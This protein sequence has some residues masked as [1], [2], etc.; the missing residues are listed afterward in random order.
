MKKPPKRLVIK[1]GRYRTRGDQTAILVGKSTQDPQYPWKGTI[2]GEPVTWDRLGR[3]HSEALPSDY[4]LI[5]RLTYIPP[6]PAKRERLEWCVV[7]WCA[8]KKRAQSLPD[9]L[10]KDGYIGYVP[11]LMQL[12]VSATGLPMLPATRKE[13]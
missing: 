1:P 10:L 9:M 8:D 3:W 12:P 4:D 5:S 2:R 11:H 13:T 7:L 6:K